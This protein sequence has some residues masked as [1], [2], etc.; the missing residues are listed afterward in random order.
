MSTR[1]NPNTNST[2]KAVV[3]VSVAKNTLLKTRQAARDRLCLGPRYPG[4][5]TDYRYVLR[6][7]CELSEKSNAPVKQ[8][9]PKSKVSIGQTKKEIKLLEHVL[10]TQYSNTDTGNAMVSYQITLSAFEIMADTRSRLDFPDPEERYLKIMASLKRRKLTGKQSRYR[11]MAMLLA[12]LK[13]IA[14][15]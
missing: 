7:S 4:K 9:V 15:G 11:V 13:I 3:D 5:P 12:H 10:R 2:V 6:E 14:L 1:V 8:R